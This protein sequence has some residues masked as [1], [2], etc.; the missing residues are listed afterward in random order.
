MKN[1]YSRR[2]FLRV[3]AIGSVGM[4]AGLL[5]LD[6]TR[7]TQAQTPTPAQP[8]VTPNA[9]AIRVGIIG[10][11]A[12]AARHIAALHAVPGFRIVAAADV[13]EDR[14]ARGVA[15]SGEKVAGYADYQKLLANPEVDAVLVATPNL[16]HKE[17]IIAAAQAGKHVLA[18]KPL[19]TS[20]QESLELQKLSDASPQIIQYGLQ[21]RYSSRFAELKRLVQSGRVGV[22][23]YF[24]IAEFRGDWNNKNVWLYTDPKTGRKINW[25]YSQKASGGTLNEK[26]CHYFD[27]LNWLA[28]DVPRT[29]FCHGGNSIY[30]D[31]ETWDNAS[32]TLQ[33]TNDL[34]ATF[35]LCMFGPNRL[36]LQVIGTE[37]SLAV[38]AEEATILWHRRNNRNGEKLPIPAEIGHGQG[39]RGNETAV[40]RLYE[41]FRDNIHA[42]RQPIFDTRAAVNAS[43]V[44][45]LG[46]LSHTEKATVAWDQ[47]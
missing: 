9:P 22:P 4:K 46:E 23:K 37:G 28:D 3:S 2:E 1:S 33:Y 6:G 20:H 11:G 14:L 5:G 39:G 12:R 27:I 45:F 42:G 10:T 41:D 38:A 19:A 13:D 40:L 29:V 15:L 24:H 47:L 35:G 32:L 36:D 44:A 8:A 34:Q 26:C 31:R 7:I 43:K 21:L 17:Q 25:R 16:F 18:E 30:T